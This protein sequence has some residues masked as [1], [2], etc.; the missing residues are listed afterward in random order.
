[1]KRSL[2]V[3]IAYFNGSVISTEDYEKEEE[4]GRGGYAV[5]LNAHYVLN[6][7]R[8]CKEEKCM[9]SFA[10]SPRSCVEYKT[11]LPKAKENAS[12]YVNPR[13]KTARLASKVSNLP[14][15]TEILYSYQSSYKFP[16]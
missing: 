15:N 14:A 3:S 13:K 6:C 8:Q 4:A 5:Y 1:L 2:L 7:Y 9:A 10:N 11:G 16:A 12:L